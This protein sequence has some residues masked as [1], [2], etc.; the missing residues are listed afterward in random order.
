VLTTSTLVAVEAA[1][2]ASL[3]AVASEPHQPLAALEIKVADEAA[4]TGGPLGA[5]ASQ[6]SEAP[7]SSAA[8]A[9]PAT[10]VEEAVAQPAAAHSAEVPMAPEVVAAPEVAAAVEQAPIESSE[11][12]AAVEQTP[13]EATEVVAAVEQTPT[14]SAALAPTEPEAAATVEPAAAHEPA[15]AQASSATE[16]APVCDDDEPAAATPAVEPIE[17][18]PLFNSAGSDAPVVLTTPLPRPAAKERPAE[19]P[20]FKLPQD[21]LPRAQGWSRKAVRS[22][23]RTLVVTAPFIALLGIWLGHSAVSRHRHAAL[24]LA[25]TQAA[26]TAAA[27]ITVAEP[28]VAPV[29]S[30]SPVEAPAPSPVLASVTDSPSTAAPAAAVASPTELAHALAHGLPA[31]EALAEKFPADSQVTI[32]LAAQQAQAQRYEAAV[33]TVEHALAV[34]P[35]NAPSGKVMGILWR[36]A[37]SPASEQSFLCLRKLGGRGTDVAF[38]LATTPGVRESVRERAKA[39]L[40]NYLAFDA[41]SDT[42]AATALLLAPDC[43]TRKALLERAE[44]DGGK[45]TFRMLERFSRGA[46]CTSSSEGACNACLMGSP[47]LAHALS[48]LGPGAKP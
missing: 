25:Q 36:A 33:G 5:E 40:T 16:S 43:A 35:S 29:A 10:A 14:E 23:P 26:A 9:A 24:Q 46:G 34:D 8:T 30:A 39:E 32:A 28:I 31:V 18:A 44:S 19:Q 2:A 42:R 38:D 7:D 45:R 4:A 3:A 21:W 27:A 20:L 6:E 48:K 12:V 13:A 1:P 17:P 22:A 11:V 47:V 37:Q 41:S 15:E